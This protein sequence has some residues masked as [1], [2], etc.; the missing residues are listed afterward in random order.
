M[1][2]KLLNEN[3]DTIFAGK[4][5]KRGIWFDKDGEVEQILEG[6]MPRDLKKDKV[7]ISLFGL[8]CVTHPAIIKMGNVFSG[9]TGI[10]EIRDRKS[11]IEI[12]DK[13]SLDLAKDIFD[14]NY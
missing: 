8:G 5:E 7:V 1:I 3:L 4:I 9:K 13:Q 11:Q 6:F 2:D 14:Y 10:F 12:R